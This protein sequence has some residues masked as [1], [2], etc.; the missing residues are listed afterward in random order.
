MRKFINIVLLI[1][2]SNFTFA[3][4]LDTVYSKS[5]STIIIAQ[6]VPT[7]DANSVNTIQQL[8]S[9]RQTDDLIVSTDR[10]TNNV[11]GNFVV[12]SVGEFYDNISVLA[13]QRLSPILELLK[14]GTVIDVSATGYQRHNNGHEDS[15]NSI[16]YT[17]VNPA[18]GDYYQ[19]RSQ[20]GSLQTEF[21]SIDIGHFTI[22]IFK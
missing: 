20:R 4:L 11:G 22:K 9:I 18:V 16:Y 15:S 14:N 19:L 1:F 2:I 8:I 7:G 12:I 5:N 17:D 13:E 6:A 3:Q 10:I 21:Q